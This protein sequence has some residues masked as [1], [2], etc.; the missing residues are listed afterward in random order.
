MTGICDVFGRS[1]RN[2]QDPEKWQFKSQIQFINSILIE[3]LQLR[4]SP[5]KRKSTTY[6]IDGIDKFDFA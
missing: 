6:F 2:R 5:I 1:K 3:C 4:I